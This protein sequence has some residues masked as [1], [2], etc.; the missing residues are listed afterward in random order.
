MHLCSMK[1][2]NQNTNLKQSAID[3]LYFWSFWSFIIGIVGGIASGTL[4]GALKIILALILP[5]ILPVYFIGLLFDNLYIKKR[6][7]LFFIIVVPFAYFSGSLFN[8]W[9]QWIMNDPNV[10]TSN[11]III[12]VF[13]LMYIGFRYIK[14]AIAQRKVLIE[15]GNKQTLAEL[16]YLTSQLNPHFLFN[17]LN[18]IYSLVLS[19]SD[20]AGE[21]VLALS[22]LM[23][24]HID[25]S[26]KQE[27]YLSEE[28]VL[29]EQYIALEQLKLENRCD[30][31]F[32]TEGNAKN[33]R[34]APLLLMPLVENAFKYSITSDPASNFVHL[35]IS[36]EEGRFVMEI[37]NSVAK[38]TAH[39]QKMSSKIG[40]SNTIK[41]LDLHYKGNYTFSTS[42]EQ[43]KFKVYLSINL[44]DYVN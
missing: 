5:H 19:K 14:L 39:Q 42:E 29:I 7:L 32:K 18:S 40:I 12:F 27:I 35:D 15:S 17:S 43:S 34:I 8:V 37:S 16:Q 13:A 9:F 36:I 20:K 4:I 26:G 38:K 1:I 33:C 30:I 21:A 25:L 44:K 23:R 31:Q 24:Y 6:V 11:E 2:F 41:R 22:E 10:E 28:I 3:S